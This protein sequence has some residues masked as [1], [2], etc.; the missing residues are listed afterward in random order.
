LRAST[1]TR[2]ANVPANSWVCPCGEVLENP[3][4]LAVA[5]HQPHYLTGRDDQVRACPSPLGVLFLGAKSSAPGR[6]PRSSRRAAEPRDQLSHRVRRGAEQP[7]PGWLCDAP[8]YGRCLRCEPQRPGRP[9]LWLWLLFPAQS[10]A[11]KWQ[12]ASARWAGPPRPDP[13]L[14]RLIQICRRLSNPKVFL[15]TV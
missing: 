15:E 14:P 10:G 5:V 3:G 2:N 11:A 8:A 7:A 9:W 4:D 1:S 12:Y 6:G 13:S